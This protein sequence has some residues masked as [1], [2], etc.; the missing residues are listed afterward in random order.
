MKLFNS[1]KPGFIKLDCQAPNTEELLKEL[2]RCLKIKNYVDDEN[3][4]L[5]K[6]L[7][8]EKLGS[9][10][11]GNYAAVPHTKLKEIKEPIICI[12][13]SKEGIR[14]NEKDKELVHLVIL[15]LSPNYSPIIHLQI[16]AAAASVIKKGKAF[17]DDILATGT[18][19]E[20]IQV[21]EEYENRDD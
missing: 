15:I 14:Y 7:E 18:A 16:L 11:I 1:L 2:I 8:R 5:E 20:L 19:E 21:V 10:S 12:G 13:T 6:L 3:A 17:I 4:I 9:T